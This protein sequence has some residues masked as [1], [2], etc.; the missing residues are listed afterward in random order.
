MENFPHENSFEERKEE[1]RHLIADKKEHAIYDDQYDDLFQC[2]E[3]YEDIIREEGIDSLSD[4]E[5]EIYLKKK[6]QLDSFS[7]KV[8]T[9][10]E[11][12]FILEELGK[13][14]EEVRVNL[15]H[16]N[17][18]ANVASSLGANHE[19]YIV[20]F[21]RN[22]NIY[23]TRVTF[24]DNLSQEEVNYISKKA[25]NAPEDYEVKGGLSEDDEKQ[26][27]YFNRE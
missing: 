5:K 7:L 12:R 25:I 14:E 4:R 17:A 23:Q 19:T 26:A 9:L 22:G 3:G 1:L 11:L 10:P 24:P 16:E 13:D 6:S 15:A 8:K 18:H 21:L 2:I 20:Y 27:K